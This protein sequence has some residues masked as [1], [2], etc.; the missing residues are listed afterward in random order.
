MAILPFIAIVSLTVPGPPAQA[1]DPPAPAVAA[2]PPLPRL[3]ELAP[4]WNRMEPGG[5]T[6]CALGADYAFHVLP[7]DPD[8]L[9][10]HFFG[11]GGCWDAEGCKPEDPG[12]PYRP[13]VGPIQVPDSLASRQGNAGILDPHHPENPFLGYTRVAIPYC[14]ADAHLG[15]RDTTYRLDAEGGVGREFVIR[16]RGR[17]NAMTALDWV[18]ENV[19][20]PSEVFVSGGSAG[21]MA[22][23]VYGR[24]LALHYPRAR[25]VALSDAAGGYRARE[26]SGVDHRA[27]GVPESLADLPGWEGLWSGGF[28]MADLFLRG[29]RGVPNL[30]LAHVD[31]G[32][33]FI[34][35][36]FLEL[37]G[38]PDADLTALIRGN[39][40]AIRA[41]LP[42]FRGYLTAGLQHTVL[43][44]PLFYRL[45]VD[46]VRLRD[47]VAALAAGSAVPDVDCGDCLRPAYLFDEV[48]L[49]IVDGAMK[50]LSAPGAW[51]S[52][53]LGPTPCP[54]EPQRFTLG[55]AVSDAAREASHP[56]AARVPSWDDLFTHPVGHDLLFTILQH[57][58]VEGNEYAALVRFNNRPGATVEEMLGVLGEVRDRIRGEISPGGGAPRPDPTLEETACPFEPHPRHLEDVACFRV[59]VPEDPAAPHGRTLRLPVAVLRADSAETR[60]DPLVFLPGGPFPSLASLQGFQSPRRDRDW[61]FLDYR[62]TGGAEPVCPDPSP[63]LARVA[64]RSASAGERH[65]LQREV[66]AGCAAHALV[67]GIDLDLYSARSHAHDVVTVVRALGYGEWNVYASS[68]GVSVAL[69]PIHLRAPGLRAIVVDGA[70]GWRALT[71]EGIA[72]DWVT[73]G[74]FGLALERAWGYCAADPD[75]T[76]HFPDPRREYEALHAR[77]ARTPLQLPITRRDVIPEGSVWVTDQTLRTTV[78]QMLY[79]PA[80]LSLIPLLVRQALRDEPEILAQAV[81]RLVGERSAML[82][83]AYWAAQCAQDAARR[84][85]QPRG[86]SGPYDDPLAGMHLAMCEGLGPRTQVEGVPAD[87]PGVPLL[88]LA[89]E[90]DPAG[91]PERARLLAE[92]FPRGRAVELPRSGHGGNIGHPCIF[93]ILSDFLAAPDDDPDA[94]CVTTLPPIR[95]ALP[96][97]EAPGAPR[98]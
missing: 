97:A 4:G 76:A 23:A 38:A 15:D 16:H 65:L 85:E 34:Q 52:G 69:H 25:V 56:D 20:D 46:G 13:E 35:R 91:P 95:F 61:V 6:S 30:T 55:C 11:G 72:G 71:A 10:V 62:G 57:L 70:A 89:G 59:T 86:G 1:S 21:G 3:G 64:A 2:V 43:E 31:H 94:S 28:D 66:A 7:G 39:R 90:H 77:L 67:A 88:V 92:R 18:L 73:A 93:R 96:G 47:W 82:S 27:W 58:P 51:D 81:D 22:T 36:T 49:R 17:I 37:L 12:V 75:C 68:F 48:D 44:H 33:D 84:R 83:G 74:G 8:R 19:D 41:G 14:T 24:Y 29:G 42:T 79:S 87:P 63:A 78:H 45:Q 60:P 54:P 9:A 5:R 53:Y 26:M 32:R 40:E 98:N 80:R 50:R